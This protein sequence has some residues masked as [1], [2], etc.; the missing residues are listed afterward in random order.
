M[1]VPSTVRLGCFA[2]LIIVLV[3]HLSLSLPSA[4]SGVLFVTIIIST[5]LVK[6]GS[7]FDTIAQ[8]SLQEEVNHMQIVSVHRLRT[9]SRF[10]Q[11]RPST[12][13]HQINDLRIIILS[14]I[15]I[16]NNEN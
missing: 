15:S 12:N 14:I 11:I 5:Q 9:A 8:Q 1:I 13:L 3:R 6:T 4:I 7:T 10:D 2:L 16:N